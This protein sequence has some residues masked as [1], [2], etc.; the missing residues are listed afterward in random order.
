MSELHTERP[1]F[2]S[3]DAIMKEPIWLSLLLNDQSGIKPTIPFTIGALR[4]Y[5]EKSEWNADSAEA[6]LKLFREME[7]YSLDDRFVYVRKCTQLQ[8]PVF[9]LCSA[10]I[11]PENCGLKFPD[12]QGLPKGIWFFTEVVDKDV[13]SLEEIALSLFTKFGHEE[14]LRMKHYS[15]DLCLQ[16]PPGSSKWRAFDYKDHETIAGVVCRSSSED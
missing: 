9:E 8:E 4:K 15:C 2:D 5:S 14:A 1:T 12:H 6:V 13:R 11:L 10:Y 16:I 7:S 3:R